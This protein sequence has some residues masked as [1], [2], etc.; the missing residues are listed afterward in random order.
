MGRLE[1]TNEKIYNEIFK[2]EAGYFLFEDTTCT[3][4]FTQLSHTFLESTEKPLSNS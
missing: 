3:K 1:E 4:K 2:K